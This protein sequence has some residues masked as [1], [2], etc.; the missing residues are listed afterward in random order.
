MSQRLILLDACTLVGLYATRRLPEIVS[1]LGAQVSVVNI[2]ASESQWVYR[3]GNAEDAR[4]REMIDL[5]PVVRSGML[6]II[7]SDDEDELQT[8][9]DLTQELDPGE[10]LTAAIAIHRHAVVATDDR[11]AERILTERSVPVR[12]TLDLI[13]TWTDARQ[14]SESELR[15]VLIDLRFR[16]TYEPRRSH[17][18]RPWWDTILSIE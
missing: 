7:T 16:A 1:Q 8:F 13:K 2:V 5:D 6:S 10:A 18:Y 9:I 4:E 12:G 15:R 3:G 11:K 14:L 17:P